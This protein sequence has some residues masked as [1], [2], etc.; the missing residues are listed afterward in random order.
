MKSIGDITFSAWFGVIGAVIGGLLWVF[1]LHS[2]VTVLQEQ[3][4]Q[5]RGD[6]KYIRDRL[7]DHFDGAGK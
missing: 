6:I 3:V 4:K 5:M 2:Q 7:D 1:K